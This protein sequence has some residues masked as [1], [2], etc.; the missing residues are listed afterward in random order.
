MHS[1]SGKREGELVMREDEHSREQI[2]I[3]VIPSNK[4]ERT[5]S[6][7]LIHTYGVEDPVGLRHPEL[8]ASGVGEEGGAALRGLVDWI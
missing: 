4:I 3:T 2:L 8:G 5:I 6:L 7:R 1:R